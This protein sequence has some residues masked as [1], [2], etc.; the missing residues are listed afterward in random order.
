MLKKITNQGPSPL[1]LRADHGRGDARGPGEIEIDLPVGASLV[2]EDSLKALL[3]SSDNCARLFHTQCVIELSPE[4]ADALDLAFGDDAAEGAV[5]ATEAQQPAAW[6][7]FSSNP[8]P[9]V[10]EFGPGG[11]GSTTREEQLAADEV[12]PSVA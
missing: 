3:E 2:D 1:C 10:T 12:K 8:D 11:F 9:N 7:Q 5:D 6:L 4:Q